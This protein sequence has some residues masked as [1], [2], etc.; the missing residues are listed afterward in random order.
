MK[1]EDAVR[2]YELF[3]RREALKVVLHSRGGVSAVRPPPPVIAGAYVGP[4]VVGVVPGDG[5]EPSV[6]GFTDRCLDHLATLGRRECR[7]ERGER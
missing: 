3:Q 2:G 4:A 6:H 5:V 7:G 1:L